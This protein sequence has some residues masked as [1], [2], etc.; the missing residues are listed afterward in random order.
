MN[1]A[2][3]EEGERYFRFEF[4]QF[5]DREARSYGVRRRS[6]HLRV[7]N[8][9]ESRPIGHASIV[10]QF[11]EG[12]ADVI[13]RLVE[14]L[15]EHDRIQVYL[16]SRRLRSAHTSA[17]VSVGDWRQSL[18]PAR[19]ILDTISRMLNSNENF[20][21]DETME[22]DLTHI[23]MPQPGTGKRNL[24]FGSANYTE[25]LKQKKSI[26][27]IK[28]QDQLC[29]ARAL[30]VAKAKVD[31]D[32][33]YHSLRHGYPILERRARALHQEAGVP[34]GPC[35]LKDIIVFQQALSEYQIIVVSAEHGHSVVY[36]GEKRDKQMILLSHD[37][38]FDVITSLP[39]FFNRSYYCLECEK[40]F[41]HDTLTH[42]RCEGIKCAGC[43]QTDCDDFQM[44]G[45]SELPHITCSYCQRRFYG[46]I[47]QTN[48]MIRTTSGQDADHAVKNSVCNT[49][50][51]CSECGKAKRTAH[52]CGESECPCCKKM[53][54]LLQHQCFIQTVNLKEE[55]EKAHPVFIYFDIEARQD[56]G[57]HVANLV[58][59]E[60]DQSDEQFTFKGDKCLEQFLAFV[61]GI[62]NQKNVSKT[63]VVAHNFKGYDGYMVMEELYRQ[64]A[65]NLEMIVNGAKLL[66]VEL[67]RVKFIDS[68]NFFPMAL[69]NFPKTFG[70]KELR[71]GFF[72]HF[73]NTIQNQTYVGPMPSV[74]YY[75]PDGMSPSRR[76]EFMT[77]HTARVT[78]QHVFD[79]AHELLTY[80]QSDV[81]LL[82]EGCMNFQREFC[83]I[84]G[85]NPMQYCITIASACNVAYRRNWMPE[86]QIAVEPLTG[87]R[88][89]HNQSHAAL[90][91][92][93]WEESRLGQESEVPRIAHVGNRGER[94]L[95][96]GR[97]H[98]FLVDG[99]D[100]TTKTVYEFQGCFF[101]GCLSCFP[102]RSQKHPRKLGKT[103][104]VVRMQTL[105][106]I[107]RM[108]ALGYTV[109]EMWECE[110]NKRKEN[111]PTIAEFVKSLDIVPPLNPRDAFF[112]GRTNAVQLYKKVDQEQQIQ[113]M[114]ITSLY[115]FINKTGCYPVGHPKYIDQPGHVNSSPYFGLVK[116]RI[117][118]PYE[119]YHPVLPYR[120]EDKLTFP[121]CRTCME[122]GFRSSLHERSM[123]CNHTPTQRAL[124]GTWCTPELQKA[125]EKGYE[126]LYVHEI[127][128]F[129]KVSED[130]FKN[131]VNTWLKIKQEASGWPRE[132]MTEEE[133]AE[134]VEDYYRREGIRLDPEKIV[135]NP[136]LRSLAK[137]MLNS[138]WGK[139][140][141]RSNQT[142][143]TQCTKPS[144]FFEML[145]DDSQIIERIEIINDDMLELFHKFKTECDAMQT[146]VNIFIAAFTTCHARLKL[147]EALE[148]LNE[149][150]LYFDTD[151]VVYTW[152]P[153][154]EQIDSGNYLGDFTSELKED[155]YIT[156]FVAA[157]PKN[158]AYA[159]NKGVVCCKVRGFTL[160]TRGQAVLN[161]ASVKDLVLAEILQPMETQRTLTL[162]NP[163]KIVREPVKK[164]LRTV[165]Q[166]KQYKLVFDKRVL[167][168]FNSYPYGYKK[169]P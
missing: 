55:D 80:C 23:T 59:A 98:E 51:V 10:R 49:Q 135:K 69:S 19:Q 54:N 104:H 97:L 29:C 79:F 119:L 162:R 147:Y 121:L 45:R 148:K 109:K 99:Y 103:M 28:N 34:I 36:K 86:K 131:Y 136:G 48:H 108:K 154:Q 75:D 153:G 105:S 33:D 41:N 35:T 114:D 71:K 150:V 43:H 56:T 66:M 1:Q 107:M 88:G 125:L 77:W 82:K 158:Y 130:L 87:W 26:I 2:E 72:P 138:F 14:D 155:E 8:P 161:F 18:G 120:H 127:W 92:L 169:V 159:T 133:K 102:N 142:R 58:C 39:G 132:G 146:N 139:F 123:L 157:G 61:H 11:E 144:E 140:G 52:K 63:I 156:E 163:H 20:D 134:Y 145:R 117:L 9:V 76:D 137:L 46:V 111:D 44:R 160:N 24:P 27:V 4:E 60:T 62:A 16:G 164:R 152:Q 90:E 110:W 91:W 57:Q 22:L 168:A 128:H 32:P 78:E 96:H 95:M 94:R 74:E 166:D 118:P 42:H 15:P 83:A 89:S 30:V 101:H 151:S 124:T 129:E 84:A 40:G 64:H 106:K 21:V 165:S 17:H 115:P 38:H 12:L 85:F 7:Q 141:Q 47:C 50:R 93:Y 167:N 37:G 81:R 13:D 116:C 68:M 112:G 113:Y 65:T 73:F 100:E 5:R 6:Y 53:V 126:I 143:T 149:R 3:A 122:N 31:D 25:L 67:P 70:L